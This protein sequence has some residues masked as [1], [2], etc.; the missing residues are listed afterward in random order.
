MLGLYGRHRAKHPLKHFH[1]AIL[2]DRGKR[3]FIDLQNDGTAL[4]HL[5]HT[6]LLELYRERALL[7]DAGCKTVYHS[8][9]TQEAQ[10]LLRDLQHFAYCPYIAYVDGSGELDDRCLQRVRLWSAEHKKPGTLRLLIVE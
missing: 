4:P 2:S 6:V 7:V 10:P 5:P 3:Q 8:A 9:G 1:Q